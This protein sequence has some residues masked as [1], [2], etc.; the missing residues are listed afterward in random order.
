M[1]ILII[2][3]NYHPELTGI[4][5]YSG[6]M[7]DWLSEKGHE[8]TVICAPPYYPDW[9]VQ[10]PYTS[11]KYKVENLNGVKAIRCPIWV[12]EK[13]SGVKRMLHL[14][15]F[16]LSI[17]PVAIG[18]VFKK[19]D[20]VFSVEPSFLN[21]FSALL[22]AKVSRSSSILHIQDFE[23]D[24][25][26]ELGI[27]KRKS[28]KTFLLFLEKKVMSLF[29]I[30]STSSEAMVD[31]LLKKGVRR[32]KAHLFPNWVDTS[33]I[34]PLGRPGNFR[35]ELGIPEDCCLALYSGNMGEKQGLEII[36]EAAE[37]LQSENIKFLMGGA[38]VALSRLKESAKNLSNI[39]WIDL[40]PLSKLNELLNSAD[41]HLLP[42]L[43]GAADLLMPSKLNAMLSSGKPIV[44]TGE[45]NTQV[46][47]VVSKCGIV[48]PPC[49][50]EQFSNAIIKL[51]ENN[52]M[53][54]ELGK[55]ARQYAE[56]WLE[57]DAIMSRFETLLLSTRK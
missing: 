7:A 47:K 46:E 22:V 6:E 24:V 54:T 36:I 5:K 40:Q 4:G 38:G 20:V 23:I 26:F 50:T 39:I 16:A 31:H 45:I 2:S 19:H 41:I 21:S 56:N 55:S 1:K 48:T 25:A 30:V 12:P 17:I 11:W 49:D 57:Y 28:L 29:D 51:S 14:L 10:K 34:F 52:S 53:R 13:V 44:A 18:Q 3:T 8:V 33:Q 15:S 32:E 27:I 42:Q 43:P 35:K 37:K 9:K